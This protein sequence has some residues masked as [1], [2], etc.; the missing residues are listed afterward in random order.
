MEDV[1]DL[2]MRG[3]F[4]AISHF[5]YLGSYHEWSVPPWG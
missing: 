1:M 5:G 4:E 3:E 2:P